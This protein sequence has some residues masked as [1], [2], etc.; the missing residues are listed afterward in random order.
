M[1]Y[2]WDYN[3]PHFNWLRREG[4]FGNQVAPANEYKS[5]ALSTV[6]GVN[7]NNLTVDVGTCWPDTHTAALNATDNS[8][9]NVRANAT[10]PGYVFV[11]GV[12]R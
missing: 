10:L 4:I 5:L 3:L 9:Y 12:R 2:W 11:I 6:N 1:A 7:A 8:A